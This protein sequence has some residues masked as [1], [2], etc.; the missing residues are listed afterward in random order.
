MGSGSRSTSAGVRRSITVRTPWATSAARPPS[1][2]R[3]SWSERTSAA[4]RTRRP[5]VV[6]SPPRSR[7]LRHASHASAR[8]APFALTAND[9]AD[10]RDADDDQE[11]QQQDEADRVHSGL[12]LRCK[13][14]AEDAAEEHEEEATPVETRERNDVEHRQIHGEHSDE[15]EERRQSELRHLPGDAEDL[16]RAADRRRVGR[17]AW[18]E[19]LPGQLRDLPDHLTRQRNGL[20]KG[21]GQ[22][23][24]D[25]ALH[26]LETDSNWAL[27]LRGLRPR[28][29]LDRG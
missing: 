5:S 17:P 1:F 13:A 25:G 3:Q 6:V 10:V 14:D 28:H 26:F 9:P 21:F 18:R 7:T 23:D 15:L 4:R 12:D 2:R 11:E 24:G 8:V 27:T 20:R 22:R 16:D 29:D 19:E